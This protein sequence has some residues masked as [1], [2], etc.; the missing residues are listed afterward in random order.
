MTHLTIIQRDG[1]YTVHKTGCKDIAKER[2]ARTEVYSF[3]VFSR[4]DLGD[5]LWGDIATD[6][7]ERYTDDWQDVVNGY[8]ETNTNIKPCVKF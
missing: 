3:E 4:D 8:L 2:A 1:D 7:F 5:N 6:E